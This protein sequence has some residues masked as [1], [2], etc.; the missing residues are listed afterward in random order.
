MKR[1]ADNSG[2]QFIMG[3]AELIC[4]ECKVE[5]VWDRRKA[6]NLIRLTI[7]RGAQKLEFQFDATTLENRESEI[8]R[9][10]ASNFLDRCLETFGV[11]GAGSS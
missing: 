10:V 3:L 4:R 9:E 2:L 11:P 7:S 8:F 6:P 5:T 1:E